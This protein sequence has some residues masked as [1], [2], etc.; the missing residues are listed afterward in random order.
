MTK[1]A[2]R[3]YLVPDKLGQMHQNP[4]RSRDFYDIDPSQ[5]L[6]G[7]QTRWYRIIH[8]SP[9]RAFNTL[10]EAGPPEV[11]DNVTISKLG[12]F[13]KLIS[14]QWYV[15]GRDIRI[16]EAAALH[17]GGFTK[18]RLLALLLSLI[19]F[20]YLIFTSLFGV[21]APAIQPLARFT[22]F[23]MLLLLVAEYLLNQLKKWLQGSQSY[24]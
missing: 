12:A 16:E 14:N 20:A 2:Y 4:R 21:D 22:G 17:E 3:V 10:W 7:P 24:H 11:S 13:M 23:F 5:Y 9:G 19:V 8:T 15:D 18:P 6:D 1:P